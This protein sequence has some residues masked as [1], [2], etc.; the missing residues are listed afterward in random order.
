MRRVLVIDDHELSRNNLTKVLSESGFRITPNDK[1]ILRLSNMQSRENPDEEYPLLLITGRFKHHWH[2]MTRTGKNEALRKSAKDPIFE[3][4]GPDAR[5]FGIQ[6]ADFVEIISRRGKV[7]VQARVT[8]E[9][10][11]GAW[12][13]PFH[14]GREHGFFKAANNRTVTARDPV[15]HHPELKACAVRVRKVSDFPAEDS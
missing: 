3:I 5:Q 8:E 7:M 10:A 13:L 14:W 4:N 11:R 6:D 12:F 9:I 2:T 15:S 1:P